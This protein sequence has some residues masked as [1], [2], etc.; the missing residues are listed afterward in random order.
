[1]VIWSKWRIQRERED[2]LGNTICISET[3]LQIASIHI[4]YFRKKIRQISRY[5][6]WCSCHHWWSPPATWFR[7]K[8]RIASTTNIK[9]VTLRI[10]IFQAF[11]KNTMCLKKLT[12]SKYMKWLGFAQS[13]RANSKQGRAYGNQELGLDVGHYNQPKEDKKKLKC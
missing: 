6:S 3:L 8:P 1:M 13:Y 10:F 7:G 5:I 4:L 9:Y 2:I 11:L 12:F